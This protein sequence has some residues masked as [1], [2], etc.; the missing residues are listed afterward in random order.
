MTSRTTIMVKR[1]VPRQ[2]VALVTNGKWGNRNTTIQK[3]GV[4]L[5]NVWIEIHI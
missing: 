4:L 3:H 5:P 2:F 1:N